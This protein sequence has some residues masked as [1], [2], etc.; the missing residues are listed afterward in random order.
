MLED[1]LLDLKETN[2]VFVPLRG[3]AGDSFITHASFQ[4][5]DRLGIPIEIGHEGGI[6]PNRVIIL[7]GGGNLVEPYP[8][9]RSFL[10]NNIG[11]CKH[12][13][14]LPHSIRAYPDIWNNLSTNTIVFCRERPS[15]DYVKA[16]TNASVMLA[17]DMAFSCDLLET[18]RLAKSRWRSDLSNWT[19][20]LRNAKC[21][22]RAIKY[23]ASARLE[24]KTLN[25][26]RT[27][28]E[29]QFEPDRCPNIDISKAF[30]V[31][32]M[33]RPASIYATAWMA[34]FIGAFNKVRTNR[35]HVGIMSAMLGKDVEFHDNSYGKNQS[36]FAYS[37][38]DRFPNV[39]MIA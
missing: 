19:L 12:L 24:T 30:A 33:L 2:P 25:A 6:Y 32:E 39:R 22:L 37:M 27:D 9:G 7:N 35:L 36:V 3:N 21:A 4:M 13:V 26:M 29:K 18:S 15:F 17:H 34:K 38:K 28:I 20:T 31:D 5:F 23:L 1:I 14:V 8:N 11:R 10:R 16:N